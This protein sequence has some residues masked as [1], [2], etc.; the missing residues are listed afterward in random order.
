LRAVLAILVLALLALARPAAAH[1][2][3]PGYLE[4]V[5][6]APFRY[7]VLWKVPA[8]GEARLVLN[9]ALPDNCRQRGDVTTVSDSA[10]IIKR[11]TVE[12]DG[13]LTGR[14][15]TIDGLQTTFTDVLA[16]V[17][18]LAGSVLTARLVPTAPTFTVTGDSSLYDVAMTYGTLG[19]HH[20]LSGFDHLLFVLALMILVQNLRSLLVTITSFTLSHSISLAAATFNLVHVPS[21]FVEAMIALS[22]VFVAVEIIR[23]RDDP[24]LASVRRPWLLAFAFGFLHGLG[25]ASALAETGLPK[26]AIPTALLFFN[27]GVE[28]GQLMF[29]AVVLAALIVARRL[30][31]TPPS[32]AWQLP[33][34]AIGI[35]AAFWTFERIAAFAA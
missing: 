22:I 19:V 7:D 16:R 11:W 32:W 14:T 8:R 2:V 3:R 1:E 27:L 33:T 15:I 28:A 17:T 6:T 23:E 24:A 20:I 12:C 5:E 29:V 10:A 34:Y 4:I 18:S 30:V 26:D 25:F 35:V 21:R 31:G 9:A 13:G